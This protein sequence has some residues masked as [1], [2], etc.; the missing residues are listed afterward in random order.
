MNEL[1]QRGIQALKSGDRKTARE[2]L[3]EAVKND[4]QDLQAW[5][6]L[7][8][9]VET[10]GERMQCLEEVLRIDPNNQS[11]TRGLALL[12]SRLK[13]AESPI[14][15]IADEKQPAASPPDVQHPELP[16]SAHTTQAAGDSPASQERL[17][18]AAIANKREAK[19]QSKAAQDNSKAIFHTRPSLVLAL[20]SFWIFLFG[21]ILI[22]G[23]LS[24]LGNFSFYFA[25]GLGLILELI[26]L[27]AVIQIMRTRYILTDQHLVVPYQ[28]KKVS[29]P[30]ADIFHA[31]S[32]QT[33][34]QKI[35]GNGDIL[36]NGVIENQLAVIR[37]RNISEC[38]Q[39]LRQINETI[40]VDS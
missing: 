20:F 18:P 13:T 30:I 22:A 5:L 26:V 2:L 10:D 28:G 7:S 38:Q 1:T 32:R 3:G 37:L 12:S 8:G 14:T 21:S 15:K 29:I 11:A 4:A 36:V 6:W 23:Q 17:I 31:E 27:Y 35:F 25:T 33:T 24:A 40:R 34:F 9:A 19:K 16:L 39:R